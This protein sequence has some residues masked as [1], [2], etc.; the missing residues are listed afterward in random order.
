MRTERCAD[1]A[2]S[3]ADENR[4]SSVGNGTGVI[5]ARILR[6]LDVS[7]TPGEGSIQY[8][9][10]ASGLALMGRHLYVIAD[11]EHSLGVFDLGDSGPGRLVRLFEGE[12]PVRH[13]ARKAEKPDLEAMTALPAFD[14]HPF[15]ALLAIGSGSKPNRQRAALMRLDEEGALVGSARHVD[16]GPLYE[17]LRNRFPD[18]NIE[19]LFVADGDLCLLQRGNRASRVNAC[20]RFAWDEIER[21]IR[22]IG[23]APIARSVSAF[24]LGEIDGVPLS[25]TDAAGLP[26]GAWVFCAAAE[27]TSDSY[28]DGRCAGSAI[29][30]VSVEGELV[31]L[32]RIDLPCKAEGVAVVADDETL[33]LLLVTDADD[34]RAPAQLLSATLPRAYL[35]GSVHQAR[36]ADNRVKHAY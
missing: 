7:T 19:G 10:A 26:T 27:D 29:G 25:F 5:N 9:S 30:I 22:D 32:E 12:P 1:A 11:D 28:A 36:D 18:L 6:T 17:P 14:A 8:L 15:G 16:L 23:P 4:R 2:Q 21:W 13:K 31:L 3:G 33:E 35:Q 20:V 34:R 24:E